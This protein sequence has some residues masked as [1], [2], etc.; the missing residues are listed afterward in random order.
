[1][2]LCGWFITGVLCGQTEMLSRSSEHLVGITFALIAHGN[3]HLEEMKPGGLNRFVDKQLTDLFVDK[4][5]RSKIAKRFLFGN[6]SL[7]HVRIYK[8]LLEKKC[9]TLFDICFVWTLKKIYS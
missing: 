2:C 6:E 4:F 1:M 5:F 3:I 7:F 9:S 8:K